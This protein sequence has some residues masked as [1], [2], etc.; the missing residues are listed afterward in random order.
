MPLS[1]PVGIPMSRNKFNRPGSSPVSV[2]TI[3]R[4]EES[5]VSAAN[6][7]TIPPSI[8]YQLNTIQST[9]FCVQSFWV[10]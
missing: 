7:T 5:L 2:W 3:R 1:E 4:E 9:V 8:V 10:V 6:R